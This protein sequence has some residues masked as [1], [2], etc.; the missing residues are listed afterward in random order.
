MSMAKIETFTEDDTKVPYDEFFKDIPP[1]EVYD[2]KEL[3]FDDKKRF[4][5][6]IMGDTRMINSNLLMNIAL[7]VKGNDLSDEIFDKPEIFFKSLEEY[8]DLKFELKD[9][10]AAYAHDMVKYFFSALKSYS[11]IL[12]DGKE[13]VPESFSV[14]LCTMSVK[15]LSKLVNKVK[16]DSDE[17]I[18]VNDAETIINSMFGLTPAVELFMNNFKEYLMKE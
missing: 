2:V 5:E 6:Y 13:M 8:V 12:P 10:I 11:L 16:V 17:W 3:S 18:L 7:L 15:D 4:I 14:L 1:T 9:T